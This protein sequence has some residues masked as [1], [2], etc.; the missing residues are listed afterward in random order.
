MEGTS[1]GLV[2][3]SLCNTLENR[4]WF[5]NGSDAGAFPLLDVGPFA[6][7][8]AGRMPRDARR[9]LD[10]VQADRFTSRVPFHGPLLNRC[11]FNWSVISLS[12]ALFCERS[13]LM[14]MSHAHGSVHSTHNANCVQCTRRLLESLHFN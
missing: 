9:S 13:Q 10:T 2:P 1:V 12:E 3:R 14:L 5:R 7:T 11:P 4:S 8:L 6:G